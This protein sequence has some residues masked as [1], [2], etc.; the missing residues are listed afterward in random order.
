MTDKKK[1]VCKGC[2]SQSPPIN[3]FKAVECLLAGKIEEA[4]Y[5]LEKDRQET[6]DRAD[7]YIKRKFKI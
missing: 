3:A 4:H 5:W 6:Y 2:Q 7:E 1:F